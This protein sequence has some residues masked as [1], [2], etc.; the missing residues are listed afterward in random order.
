MV[1]G[2][3]DTAKI[4]STF[5]AD[6]EVSANGITILSRRMRIK[7][8]VHTMRERCQALIDADGWCT[9]ILRNFLKAA[10]SRITPAFWNYYPEYEVLGS[11]QK[12]G[13]LFVPSVNAS[14]GPGLV[15]PTPWPCLHFFLAM[16]TS[17]SFFL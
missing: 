10:F 5:S 12:P 11:D 9:K 2:V 8:L 15:V 16:H 14:I 1:L 17:T 3:L 13:P 6:R 7:D 4:S